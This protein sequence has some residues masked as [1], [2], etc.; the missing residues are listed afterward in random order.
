MKARKEE[1]ARPRNRLPPKMW[2]TMLLPKIPLE[3]LRDE[4]R[5]LSRTW[6]TFRKKTVFPT[7][8]QSSNR[9]LRSCTIHPRLQQQRQ[10][11]QRRFSILAASINLRNTFQLRDIIF[12]QRITDTNPLKCKWFNWNSF[13]FWLCYCECSKRFLILKC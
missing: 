9:R 8:A 3:V 7:K 1:K 13:L 11:Q 4:L 10:R 6:R 12:F 2:L 5:R